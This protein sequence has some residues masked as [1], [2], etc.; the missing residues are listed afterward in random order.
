MTMLECC[1]MQTKVFYQHVKRQILVA[2]V[3]CGQQMQHLQLLPSQ[4]LLSLQ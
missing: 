4:L 3:R 2:G 1:Y